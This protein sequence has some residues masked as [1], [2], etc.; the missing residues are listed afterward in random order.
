MEEEEE[1]V[2]AEAEGVRWDYCPAVRLKWSENGNRGVLVRQ[3][4]SDTVNTVN[5]LVE[6]APS[7]GRA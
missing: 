7:E 3:T 1:E 6:K 2:E 4:T 5:K